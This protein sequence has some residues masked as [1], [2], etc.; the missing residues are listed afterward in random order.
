MGKHKKRRPPISEETRAKYRAAKLGLK[1]PLSHH[2]KGGIRRHKS[3]YLLIRQ[4]DHPNALANGYILAHRLVMSEYL[5]RPLT[6]EE[7]V[8]HVNGD[9]TDNR[10]DNLQLMTTDNHTRHHATGRTHTVE[11]RQKISRARCG[12]K[13]AAPLSDEARTHIR[14]GQRS[15]REAEAA[16]LREVKPRGGWTLT[17][18]TRAR[19]S[20]AR[21]ATIERKRGA[22][23]GANEPM[24]T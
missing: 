20:A 22:G 18:D 2:W 4:P 8:H 6:D 23:M 1:G 10:L 21:R 3:G 14:E 16:G 19:L 7:I 5:G 13:R 11:S 24:P 15:R 17:P 12:Q 9:K